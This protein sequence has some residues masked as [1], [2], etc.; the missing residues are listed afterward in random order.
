MLGNTRWYKWGEMGTIYKWPE[1]N[2]QLA[3]LNDPY[4]LP[5][6]IYP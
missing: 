5:E 3:C 2:R 1:K 6:G 4:N